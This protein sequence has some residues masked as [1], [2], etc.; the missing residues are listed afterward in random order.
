MAI[1]FM[2]A[3]AKQ[4]LTDFD[5]RI[6]QMEEAGKITT[7]QKIDGFYTHKASNWARLAWFKPT[8]FN[9]RLRFNIH[10]SDKAKVSTPVYG[11]YHG[12]LV[13][14]FLN[15]FDASF[16]TAVASARATADDVVG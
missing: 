9:D 8:V 4:L 3:K 6:A 10:P 5:A 2:T 1:D 11:Y 16:A 7:W 15:H 12:H 14:T 13:E